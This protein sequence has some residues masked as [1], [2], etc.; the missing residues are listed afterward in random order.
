MA[1]ERLLE[2]VQFSITSDPPRKKKIPPPYRP[3]LLVRVE[4]RR[5][6][7]ELLVREIAPPSLAALGV[8]AVRSMSS[9]PAP[10]RRPLILTAPPL[11]LT[12]PPVSVMPD[13]A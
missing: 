12:F 1:S 5:V 13:S 2:T 10:A 9:G 8:L 6:S 4:L 7:V 11:A 3:W